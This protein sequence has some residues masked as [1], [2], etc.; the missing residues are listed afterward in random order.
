M[1]WTLLNWHEMNQRILKS[2]W[3]LK[4]FKMEWNQS[5]SI[6]SP[7]CQ[8]NLSNTAQWMNFESFWLHS[9]VNRHAGHQLHVMNLCFHLK[10]LK[11]VSI[12]WNGKMAIL[13]IIDQSKIQFGTVIRR[14]CTVVN[15]ILIVVSANAFSERLQ[16]Q[17]FNMRFQEA[18]SCRKEKLWYCN[19]SDNGFL[20]CQKHIYFLMKFLRFFTCP[21]EAYVRINYTEAL[22]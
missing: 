2:V 17:T 15:S 3:S 8:R 13:E 10:T 22:T 1:N 7:K 18:L 16:R 11:Y 5:R 12:H 14:G 4:L 19:A 20:S 6:K 21:Q 9:I